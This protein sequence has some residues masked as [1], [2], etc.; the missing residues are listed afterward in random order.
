MGEMLYEGRNVGREGDVLAYECLCVRREV[1]REG[2]R[3]VRH[4][5]YRIFR[6][7]PADVEREMKT[8]QRMQFSYRLMRYEILNV[9]IREHF[10]ALNGGS[11][12]SQPIRA[13]PMNMQN[14]KMG[15]S[16]SSNRNWKVKTDQ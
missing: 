2:D 8:G 15:R 5:F 4:A 11:F 1:G 14:A 9:S 3:V 6:A 10:P 16:I 12:E 13:W 7:G